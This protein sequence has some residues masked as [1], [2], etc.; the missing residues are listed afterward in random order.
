MTLTREQQYRKQ[1][2]R[3]VIEIKGEQ[4]N[5][6]DLGYDLSAIDFLLSC[7]CPMVGHMTREK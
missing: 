2:I 3:E 6:K 5:I 7:D 1:K 4:L